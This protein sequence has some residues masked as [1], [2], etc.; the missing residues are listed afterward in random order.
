MLARGDDIFLIDQDGTRTLYEYDGSKASLPSQPELEAACAAGAIR[1]GSAPIL[2][3]SSHTEAV[4][5]TLKELGVDRASMT[6]AISE[7]SDS[8]GYG[9]SLELNFAR[10]L[11]LAGLEYVPNG[12]QGKA[13]ALW[14]F[15][16]KGLGWKGL[17]DDAPV[18]L[19]ASSA[20]TLFTSTDFWKKVFQRDFSKMD[21]EKVNR[22]IKQHLGRIGFAEVWWLKPKSKDVGKQLEQAVEEKDSA[23]AR[24]VLQEQNWSYH[25][26][27][28]YD[29][30]FDRDESTGGVK[31]I[32]VK[33]GSE[34][35]A[36]IQVRVNKRA[37]NT[38]GWARTTSSKPK[39]PY[40][41]LAKESVEWIDARSIEERESDKERIQKARRAYNKL[42][43]LLRNKGT[44]ALKPVVS[45]MSD[46]FWAYRILHNIREMP[47]VVI[48][49]PRAMQKITG[50]TNSGI[51]TNKRGESIMTLV[52]DDTRSQFIQTPDLVFSYRQS[53]FTHE[54]AHYL[55]PGRTRG[56]TSAAAQRAGGQASY[57]NNPSEITAY[58]TEF[59]SNILNNL[60]RAVDYPQQAEILI[61]KIVGSNFREFKESF[62][63]VAENL[64]GRD[65]QRDFYKQ[66]TD[67]NKKRVIKRLYGMWEEIEP[68]VKKV[69]NGEALTK[70]E[71]DRVVGRYRGLKETTEWIDARSIQETQAKE[72][73][74][75]AVQWIEFNGWGEPIEEAEYDGRKVELNQPF[76]IDHD[77]KKFAVYVK[78][79]DKVK[80]VRFGSADME[81]KRDDDEA[82]KSFRARFE[83]DKD[84]PKTS[85]TYWSCRMWQKG[86]SVSDMLDSE[87]QVFRP[88]EEV[89]QRVLWYDGV[90]FHEVDAREEHIRWMHRN[91]N[92]LGMDR[93][94]QEAIDSAMEMWSEEENVWKALA[95][96]ITRTG[97]TRIRTEGSTIS[98]MAPSA[99]NGREA[100]MDMAEEYGLGTDDITRVEVDVA[101]PNQV[102]GV[103]TSTRW[104]GRELERILESVDEKL[105]PQNIEPE[106]FPNPITAAMRKVFLH[107]GTLDK[108]TGDDVVKTSTKSWPA[109]QLNPTQSAIF[110][111]KSLGMAVAG[112]KGGNLGAIIS[113]DGYILDGHH[114][115]AATMFADPKAQIEGVV[116][117][118]PI[119]DLVP[120]LRAAG[121]A[122]GNERR[123]AP[124]GGND[125]NV[126]EASTKDALA[127]IREGEYMSPKFY[128]REESVDW[129]ERI[130]GEDVLSKRLN[131]IQRKRP[132]AGAPQRHNMPVI[133]ADKA[134]HTMVAK[135]LQQGKIDVYEPYA[136][137]A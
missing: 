119:E 109:E 56:R 112:I 30:E 121:D 14:D 104:Q 115:W 87:D 95:H 36:T 57:F 47:H 79:G 130:G 70:K 67:E 131:M 38:A 114:R 137:V 110:M 86:K 111:G 19:K 59:V 40:R 53:V 107:K 69:K 7:P 123:G 21:D 1:E 127:A 103:S 5:E 46:E 54:Y 64:S 23:K 108:E 91:K 9:K 65:E 73:T 60:N 133:D 27:G 49:S 125:I 74:M 94:E 128:N 31:V 93:T 136:D 82:R 72:N 35:F 105:Q 84:H 88:I 78:D 34:Q 43:R 96:F 98:V 16:P 52:I 6:E 51:G 68:L 132:P 63:R 124:K 80:K 39:K 61:D 134:E 58:F 42:L 13:G 18:N 32:R 116:V 76:R 44:G 37:G 122:L 100:V 22:I 135:L 50:D 101:D 113:R 120:V 12:L 11:E 25:K 24:D 4:S 89:A 33:K 29:I 117:D 75:P 26:L 129:L 17:P 77:D 71:V 8:G 83:C 126:Y 92:K 62:A 20:R 55:D 10:A 15:R 66:L 102:T 3:W 81:I 41:S 85:A 99:R 28:K 45:D 90:Q 48:G 118:M 97:W 2:W 106:E